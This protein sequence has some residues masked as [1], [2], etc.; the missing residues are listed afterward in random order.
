MNPSRSY[1]RTELKIAV[2]S[3]GWLAAGNAR[4]VSI[5]HISPGQP[6]AYEVRQDTNPGEVFELRRNAE[7][8]GDKVI[9]PWLG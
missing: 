1:E 8:A 5:P 9:A 4:K 2:S 6:S 7:E 3:T